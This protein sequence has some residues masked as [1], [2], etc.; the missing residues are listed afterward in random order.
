MAHESVR[1]Q[2]LFKNIRCVIPKSEAMRNL[3]FFF[4]KG[5]SSLRSE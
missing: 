1:L 3:S 4:R 5:D 2:Q